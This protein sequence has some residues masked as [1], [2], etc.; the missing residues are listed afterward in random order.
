M[1]NLFNRDKSI[2]ILAPM[3]GDIIEITQVEDEVFSEKM[4][5]DGVAIEPREGIVVSPVQGRIVQIFPTKHALG[6]E[7]EDGLEILIHIGLD[8]VELKG[9]G[10]KS[11]VKVGDEV[12][13]GDKLLEVDLDFIRKSGRSTVS[14]III[15]NMDIVKNI[16]TKIGNVNR[17][18]DSIMNVVI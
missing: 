15:T 16:S 7:T 17:G 5:G 18:E 12:K 1:F 13:L 11:Y 3:T 9:E 8:T 10:F 14:P 4:V 2:S 6:I